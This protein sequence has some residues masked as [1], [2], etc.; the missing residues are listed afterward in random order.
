M[1]AMHITPAG[2]PVALVM[3]RMPC[4]PVLGVFV[5]D[6]MPLHNAPHLFVC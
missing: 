1:I 6:D 5:E 2:Q 4:P 3:V